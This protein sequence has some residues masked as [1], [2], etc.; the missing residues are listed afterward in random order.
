MIFIPEGNAVEEIF[1]ECLRVNPLSNDKA[2]IYKTWLANRI[3]EIQVI[4]PGTTRSRVN[5]ILDQNGGECTPGAAIY[6]HADCHVLKVRIE[7]ES[8]SNS[9]SGSD[10]NDND[11]V[12]ATSIPYLGFFIND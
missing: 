7:F 1:Q 3:S 10:F 11:K 6:S 9:D 2:A 8:T 5:Q 12:K 4:T